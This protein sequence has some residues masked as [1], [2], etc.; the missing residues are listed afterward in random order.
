MPTIPRLA[1]GSLALLLAAASL[2]GAAEATELRVGLAA[3]PTSLDPHF[4]NNGVNNSQARHVFDALTH[5]DANQQITLGLAESWRL[6]DDTTWEFRLRRNVTFHDGT[7]FTAD[8]VAFSLERAPRV[9][10]SPSSFGTFTKQVK[11]VEVV[12]P[13]TIRIHTDGPSPLLAIDLSSVAI[14]S[15]R[16]GEGASTADYQAVRAAIGTGPYR[17]VEHLPGD[18]MVYERNPDYWGGAEPWERVTFRIVT[19]GPARVAAML[20]GDVDMINEV[21]STDMAR[22]RRQGNV[23]L[24][25]GSTNRM[26]FLSVDVHNEVPMPGNASDNAG[27]PLPRNPMRDLRVRQAL[28]LAIDR[29][30]IVDRVNEGEAVRANQLVPEGFFGYNPAIQPESPDPERARRLLAEAGYPDGFRIVLHTS[31]DRIVNA[32]RTVQAIASMWGRIGIRTAVETMP[33][34]VYSGRTARN[35]LSHMLHSWGAGTGEAAGTFVGIVHTRGGA[36]GGSNRGRYSNPEVDAAIRQA[37]VTVDEDRRRAILQETMVKVM[38]DRAIIPL[39][40]WVSTWATRPDLAY[41][42]QANQS[43][44]AMATRRAQ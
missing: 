36:Y 39:V 19:L 34:T 3:P 22:M 30:V 26:T 23:R 42:P 6:V 12:D 27:N 37:L 25:S 32:T 5:Q 1:A 21:P 18:R 16:H 10:N 13:H 29:D 28:S 24:W 38:N 7:P 40:F 41:T 44:L 20:A 43:T 4:H 33:H 31:N 17:L 9:P 35:E 2:H 14:I 11:R 15:R 8:D